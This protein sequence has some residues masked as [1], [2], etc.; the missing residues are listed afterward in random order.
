MCEARVAVALVAREAMVA[1]G[2]VGIAMVAEELG[3]AGGEFDCIAVG[4]F[5]VAV[6]VVAIVLQIDDGVDKYMN[7]IETQLVVVVADAVDGGANAVV[8]DDVVSDLVVAKS[9]CSLILPN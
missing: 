8:D 1:G 4:Y 9:S 5:D 2:H 6:V 3:I 7:Y